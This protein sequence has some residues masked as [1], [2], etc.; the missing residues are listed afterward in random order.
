MMPVPFGFSVGDCISVCLL[1]KDT[2]KALDSVRGAKAEYKAVIQELWELDRASLEVAGLQETMRHRNSST[3]EL[4]A[5]F[6]T[7]GRAVQECKGSI[8]SFLRTIKGCWYHRVWGL[9]AIK[10]WVNSL[11]VYFVISSSLGR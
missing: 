8:K 10:W 2:I 4:N 9:I 5:L 11:C 7:V 3:K 6:V 1:I